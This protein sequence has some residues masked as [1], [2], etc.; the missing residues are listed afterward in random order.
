MKQKNALETH[1]LFYLRVTSPNR[2]VWC[3]RALHLQRF[4]SLSRMLPLLFLNRNIWYKGRKNMS[5]G[6]GRAGFCSSQLSLFPKNVRWLWM[7]E[8][9]SKLSGWGWAFL[10][11][12][13]AKAGRCFFLRWCTWGSSYVTCWFLSSLPPHLKEGNGPR[14]HGPCSQAVPK[15]GACLEERR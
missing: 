9:Y 4:I 6:H 14:T 13:T 3:R 11:V 1:T 10:L 15:E 12:P 7:L 5:Q 8:R 2:P